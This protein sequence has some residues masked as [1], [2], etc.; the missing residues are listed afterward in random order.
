MT[1]KTE[2]RGSQEGYH[3]IRTYEAGP[4]GEKIKYWVP[5]PRPK[6]ATSRRLKQDVHKQEQNGRQAI[7]K[8]ARLINA[9]YIE[10]DYLIGLD[11]N[12]AG[13]D[14]L[15]RGA[16]RRMGSGLSEMDALYDEAMHQAE[17]CIRRVKED[18]KKQEIELR[19]IVTT[20]DMDGKTGE[21]VRLHHHIVVNREAA[22]AF[23]RKWEKLGGV[24][25]R[26]LSKQKDYT[27][28]A[29]Y[30]LKQVRNRPN[31]NKYIP[32]RNLIRPA[33]KD[34]IAISGSELRAPKGAEILY[35]SAYAP[36]MSQY[37]RY[38]IMRPDHVRRRDGPYAPEL[39]GAGNT[40]MTQEDKP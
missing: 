10:G 31:T 35:R 22:A 33:P 4:V 19:Y 40:T 6:S 14:R 27:P 11:Y 16:A 9:N 12:E 1:Q 25:F 5:G 13:M 39:S 2:K 7:K 8:L 26:P 17:L 37:I 21:A 36:G 15:R 30:L 20:S 38:F 23:G 32:S 29:E 24:N 18:L 34:R 3:V 28:I